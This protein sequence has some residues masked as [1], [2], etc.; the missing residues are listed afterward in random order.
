MKEN[1]KNGYKLDHFL[2]SQWEES[3][4]IE[5]LYLIQ[6]KGQFSKRP[7][8]F[9]KVQT[10]LKSYKEIVKYY[11]EVTLN[12]SDPRGKQKYIDIRKKFWAIEWNIRMISEDLYVQTFKL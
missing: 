9:E 11:Q 12:L 4:M 6:P 3:T 10:A 5:N 2:N 7:F 8:D 1:F